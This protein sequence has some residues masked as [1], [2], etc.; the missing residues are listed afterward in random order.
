MRRSI[1]R[2][3]GSRST[4][5][6]SPSRSCGLQGRHFAFAEGDRIHTENSHKYT[7]TEFQTLAAAAGWRPVKAWTDAAD[8]F[9]L[10]LL[11]L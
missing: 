4:S 7:V 6:A 10:H 9:S 3:G 8:L 1:T 11:R 2:P 5:G